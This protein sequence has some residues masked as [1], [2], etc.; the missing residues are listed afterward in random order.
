M[1]KK[2]TPYKIRQWWKQL[3]ELNWNGRFIGY[4]PD[5]G[6]IHKTYESVRKRALSSFL[7]SLDVDVSDTRGD[8]WARLSTQDRQLI[9]FAYCIFHEEEMSAQTATQVRVT[10]CEMK[11]LLDSR[12]QLP[13]QRKPTQN[14]SPKLTSA[15]A[16]SVDA[17]FLAAALSGFLSS[18][19][20]K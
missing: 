3:P 17:F 11:R 6:H 1:S 10:V 16:R 20:M 12:D 15:W 8:D 5:Y 4:N 2:I 18:W 14:G 7:N 9:A 13:V 19:P